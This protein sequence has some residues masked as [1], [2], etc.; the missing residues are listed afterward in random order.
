MQPQRPLDP[1][2]TPRDACF[3]N[4]LPPPHTHTL[5]LPPWSPHRIFNVVYPTTWKRSTSYANNPLP[6]DWL[7][8]ANED[9]RKRKQILDVIFEIEIC[10]GI[11][12]NVFSDVWA[13]LQDHSQAPHSPSFCIKLFSLKLYS[14]PILLLLFLPNQEITGFLMCLFSLYVFPLIYILGHGFSLS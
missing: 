2:H 10:P 7:Q 8:Y 6:A 9:V 5:L 12:D 11:P 3:R 1:A 14:I 4:E 13:F